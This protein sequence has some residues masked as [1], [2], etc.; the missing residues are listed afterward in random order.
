MIC[1]DCAAEADNNFGPTGE[2]GVCGREFAVTVNGF[3][4]RHGS[5]IYSA[6]R[7][8]KCSGSGL[9]AM[10]GH[11]LCQGCDCHHKR[12]GDCVSTTTAAAEG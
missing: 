2:C 9:P 7:R 8:Q 5:D 4:P 10:R 1:R 6:G 12:K 11:A 3:L